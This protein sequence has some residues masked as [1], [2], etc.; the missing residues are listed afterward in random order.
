VAPWHT[1]DPQSSSAAHALFAA[2]RRH[3]PPQSMSVSSPFFTLSEHVS[4][5]EPA[6]H[7]PLWQSVLPEHGSPAGHG[8]QVP[9]QSMPVSVPFLTA[10]LQPD[11]KL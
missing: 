8:P 4:A 6:A 10:S 7:E 11:V 3:A 9:P 1:R 5:H 2:Q